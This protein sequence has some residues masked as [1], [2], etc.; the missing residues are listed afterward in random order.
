MA[1]DVWDGGHADPQLFYVA[2]FYIGKYLFPTFFTILY[3]N[4]LFAFEDLHMHLI[5]RISSVMFDKIKLEN[6][7]PD[8]PIHLPIL[9]PFS[10]T[11]HCFPS[12]FLLFYTKKD[13]KVRFD[14]D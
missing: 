2:N 12:S 6:C 10:S 5:N 8:P 9:Y 7:I 11:L 13:I 14:H 4:P 3:N 1:D